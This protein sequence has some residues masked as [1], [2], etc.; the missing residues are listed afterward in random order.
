MLSLM[1]YI[2]QPSTTLLVMV[3]ILLTSVLMES[4]W[5]ANSLREEDLQSVYAIAIF[6]ISL[7]R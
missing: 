7:L 4:V 2:V 1:V 6:I 5:T 3:R